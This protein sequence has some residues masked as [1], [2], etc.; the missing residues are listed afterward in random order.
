MQGSNI[1]ESG[2]L[3]SSLG[4]TS[5]LMP[6]RLAMVYTRLLTEELAGHVL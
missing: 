4:R 3:L 6:V 1:S 2:A 5:W